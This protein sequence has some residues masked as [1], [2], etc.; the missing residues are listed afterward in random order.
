MD[1]TPFL[2]SGSLV[3]HP[4][5]QNRHT[6]CKHPTELSRMFIMFL[7]CCRRWGLCL[8]SIQ[9]CH[10]GGPL[11]LY[12][13]WNPQCPSFPTHSPTKPKIAAMTSAVRRRMHRSKDSSQATTSLDASRI[14][15]EVGPSL[16]KMKIA[17]PAVPIPQRVGIATYPCCNPVLTIISSLSAPAK[18]LYRLLIGEMKMVR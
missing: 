18:Q 4:I 5:P 13:E 12:P 3:K 10:A 8:N 9:V 7:M 16:A 17:K 6:L 11:P 14:G 2:I 1:E 15:G